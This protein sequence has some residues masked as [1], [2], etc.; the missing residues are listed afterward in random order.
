MRMFDAGAVSRYEET[1]MILQP[2]SLRRKFYATAKLDIIQMVYNE[3]FEEYSFW[4]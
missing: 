2:F 3:A 1:S 4:L